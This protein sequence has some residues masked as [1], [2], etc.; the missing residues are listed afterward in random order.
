MEI[1]QGKPLSLMPPSPGVCQ[2]CAADHDPL[3]MH[4]RDSLYYQTLFLQEHGRA[5]TWSDA[6]AHCDIRLKLFY[7]KQF[8]MHFLEKGRQVPPDLAPELDPV[9][10]GDI[11]QWQAIISALPGKQGGGVV[12]LPVEQCLK[13]ELMHKDLDAGFVFSEGE[14]P[15]DC[16]NAWLLK[17]HPDFAPRVFIAVQLREDY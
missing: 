1:R 7:R 3:F 12:P 11:P 6:M 9:N 10:V 2:V 13:M 16:L 14:G 15:L 5:P 4:N 8:R 17:A